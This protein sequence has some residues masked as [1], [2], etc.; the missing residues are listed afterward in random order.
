MDEHQSKAT[1][2]RL[3]FFD[4]DEVAIEDF[5]ATGLILDIGGGGEGVIGRLKGRQVIAIDPNRRELE[6]AAEGPLKIVMDAR[7]LL[8]LDQAFRAV[9]SFYTLMYI[10]EEDAL[11][12]IFDEVHRVLTRDGRFLIWDAVLPPR[13]EKGKDIA[14]VPL[15][16]R[17]PEE[18]LTVG[19]GTSWPTGG[20]GTELYLRLAREAGFTVTGLQEEGSRFFLELKKDG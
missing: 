7:E 17:L 14:V 8:F 9:T 15:T 16:I 10:R 6:E 18:K 3:F 4:M 13:T 1:E 5:E 11:R 12:R 19:Y 20:R 2:D